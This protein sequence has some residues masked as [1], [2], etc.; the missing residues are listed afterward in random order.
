VSADAATIT[1]GTAAILALRTIT[2]TG[3]TATSGQI[4]ALLTIAISAAGATVTAGSVAMSSFNPTGK[5]T[6]TGP[7]TTQWLHPDRVL[8]FAG[9]DR[10]TLW[11]D[12]AR[13]S[14]DWQR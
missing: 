13:N 6:I 3:Q 4:T 1:A 14:T 9:V 5:P 12:P 8:V 2:A 7:F 11:E 10:T